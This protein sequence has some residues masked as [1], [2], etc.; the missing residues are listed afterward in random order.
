MGESK[1]N[2]PGKLETWRTQETRRKHNNVHS[3]SD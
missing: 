1:I 2:N 3:H